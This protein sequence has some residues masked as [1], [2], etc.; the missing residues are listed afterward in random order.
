MT[1]EQQLYSFEQAKVIGRRAICEES[2]DGHD[3]Q[4]T[5][6]QRDMMGRATVRRYSCTRCDVKVRLEYPPL[7]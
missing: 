1:D 6:T 7:G 5:H 3:L 2:H 4:N